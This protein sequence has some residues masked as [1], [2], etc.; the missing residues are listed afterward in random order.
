MHVEVHQWVRSVSRLV[1][2]VLPWPKAEFRW[3]TAGA[4]RRAQRDGGRTAPVTTATP[5][6][7]AN[8]FLPA[9]YCRDCGR[10][11]WAVFSPES[12]DHD[13]EFDTYKIRRAS[14]GQDKIRVRNLI[15][16]TDREAAR[17][18]GTAPMAAGGRG[19]SLLAA[20]RAG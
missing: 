2:G 1:R 6:Q 20:A 7:A 15:A 5:G 10:S 17:G 13:V 16:A 9:V 4:G 14:T 8:L 12:D 3:D 19:R 18:P 11:G